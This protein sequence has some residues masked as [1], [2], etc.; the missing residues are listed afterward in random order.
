MGYLWENNHLEN[1]RGVWNE[2]RIISSSLFQYSLC[3]VRAVMI[4]NYIL[5]YAMYC[6]FK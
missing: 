3:T 2:F 4:K 6:G 1:Q 5:Y